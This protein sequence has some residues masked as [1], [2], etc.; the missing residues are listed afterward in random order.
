G[1]PMT[2][3]NS[4]F[5]GD[6]LD[7][8]RAHFPD[9]CVDLVYLDPPFNSRANYNLLFRSPEGS[10]ADAQVE[11]FKDSWHWNDAAA[12]AFD[13]VMRSGHSK[14]FDL[15]AA[16]RSALGTNDMM[17][18]LAMMAIRLIE[19]HRVLKAEGSLYLHCDPTASHYLKLLLDAVFGAERFRNEI[20]WKR[21]AAHS[22]GGRYGRNTDTIL[23]Y[24][25]GAKPR[26]NPLF[27]PYDADY[28]ARFRN[29]DPDGRRWMDDNLTAKGLSG[30][31]YHY[32]Y[33]GVSSYWRMPVETMERLD[34]EGRLHFTRT[35]GIR[36]KRYLDEARGSPVQAL[37]T[38]I[39]ALNSQAQER[40]GYPT[41]KPI[42]LLERI[43]AASSDP[44]D[45]VLD[46]F[47][48]CGTAVHA[49]EKLGRRWAGIDITHLAIGLIE[50]RMRDAFPGVA[51]R[52]EGTPRD[53]ASAADLA[54]RDRF[55]FQWWALS[56]IDAVP[57]GGRRKGADGGID[58]IIY[59]RAEGRETARA[60]VSVKSG[61]RVG[62]VRDLHSAMERERAPIGVI[63]TRCPPSAPML[64][65]AAAVGRFH[66]E[67]TGRSYARMQIL[68]VDELFRGR[69]PDIPLVDHAAAFRTAPRERVGGEQAVLI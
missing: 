46:P 58:G 25:K 33:K 13:Q 8:L 57:Y 7:V 63:L 54:R 45:L 47:C 27:T 56:M 55:Q 4:L 41:Q 31:G 21:T 18:Y 64:R 12:D 26:W 69:R 2:V 50:K 59:F 32:A 6:N 34:R 49:A 52:V 3:A 28:A 67:A 37:W 1:A 16:F 43:I 62:V 24:A 61:E 65:E 38:D 10:E 17:A 66:S 44:G 39:P 19:L 48:G 51:L 40:L 68:T 15:L 42:A 60:L 20:T 30:G 23:F 5:Y 36:L 11:A 29:R 9:G 53:C 22:D 14:A 35:G